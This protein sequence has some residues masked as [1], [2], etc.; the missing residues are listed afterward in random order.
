MVT[1]SF[2][3]STRMVTQLRCRGLNETGAATSRAGK[4]ASKPQRPRRVSNHHDAEASLK[5]AGV[6]P[7]RPPDQ[8]RN[9]EN[10]SRRWK[11]RRGDL[12]NRLFSPTHAESI[13][14]FLKPPDSR[15]HSSRWCC[16]GFG[17]S[18]RFRPGGKN[19]ILGDVASHLEISRDELL[20][21]LF[22]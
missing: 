12:V 14:R 10:D 7:Q 18:C 20:R 22:E 6:S 8:V 13:V 16:D 19:R 2:V 21:R 4:L 1:G 5:V 11:S 9:F 17:P 15:R 3:R